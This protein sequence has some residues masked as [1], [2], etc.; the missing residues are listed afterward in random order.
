MME[1]PLLLDKIKVENIDV[2]IKEED[3]SFD[4]IEEQEENYLISGIREEDVLNSNKI[5]GAVDRME[6]DKIVEFTYVKVEE[7]GVREDDDSSN[8]TEEEDQLEINRMPDVDGTEESSIME[9]TQV[10]VEGSTW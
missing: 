3:V 1:T 9:F 7:G 6:E 5:M 4:L 8:K 2:G 10:K